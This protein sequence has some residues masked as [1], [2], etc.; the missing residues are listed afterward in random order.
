MAADTSAHQ[1]PGACRA[2]NVV[3]SPTT[4]LIRNSQPRKNGHG[5]GGDLR[6]HDCQ[7]TE[8]HEH[9]A[10]EQEQLPMVAHG[11]RQ[12]LL[13][14]IDVARIDRHVRSPCARRRC[15][16]RSLMRM[17]VVTLRQPQT[18][19]SVPNRAKRARN[20][21]RKASQEGQEWMGTKTRHQ[22]AR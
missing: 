15:G 14:L 2:M 17:Q 13:H 6:H 19:N 3:A 18:L 11:L 7:D 16:D 5:E 20:R 10:F 8:Q 22:H 1:K 21:A 12:R 4:P 9:D